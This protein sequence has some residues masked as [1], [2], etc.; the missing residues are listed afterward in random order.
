M[1]S[2][3]LLLFRRDRDSRSLDFQPSQLASP[4]P[5]AISLSVS[6]A[7]SYRLDTRGSLAL[8]L[9]VNQFI[10]IATKS[11]S[12][13]V[14]DSAI[15]QRILQVLL[16]AFSPCYYYCDPMKFIYVLFGRE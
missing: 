8:H 7:H 4:A 10:G 5:K 15:L 2:R 9:C 3:E 13:V 11:I 6:E 16:G 1:L 12:S 14:I